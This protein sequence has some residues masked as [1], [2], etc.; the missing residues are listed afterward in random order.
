MA[1][2]CPH[3][4]AQA[5]DEAR[6]CMKCGRERT[7][8]REPD[9]QVPSAPPAAPFGQPGQPGQPPVPPLSPPAAPPPPAFAPGGPSPVGAFFGRAFRGDWAGS[10]QAALW[11]VGLLV[12]AAVALAI[13][14]YG[15]GSDVV[16]GFGDRM[17]ISLALLLQS[18][19]GGFEVSASSG[20]S[21]FGG[22]GSPFG[23]GGGDMGA[24]LSGGAALSL[25]PLTVTALWILALWIGVRVLRSRLRARAA[26]PDGHPTP[27]PGTP[28]LEA[29]LR[30]ALLVTVGVLVLGLFAQPSI[31]GVRISSSPV[32]AALGALLISLTVAAGMLH[33]DD[34]AQWLAAR[35]GASAL[36]RAT[37]TALR[38]L[39]VVLVI[40]SVTAFIGIAQIDDLG[41]VSDV[42]D[43]GQ[44]DLSP[45]VV[46][47]LVLPNLGAMALGLGWGAPISFEA[48]GS[49][50]YG[51]GFQHQAFGLS[52][53]GDATNSWA[54]VGALALGTVCALTVGVMAAR[55]SADRREQLLSAGIFLCL[56]LLLGALGGLGVQATGAASDLGG[57]GTGSAGVGL[58]MAEALLF[59]L[60]WVFAA[61]FLAPYLMQMAGART[62]IVPEP[63]VPPGA[64]GSAL[65]VPGPVTAMPEAP[66]APPA[67]SEPPAPIDPPS[68]AVAAALPTATAAPTPTPTP[69]PGPTP[70]PAAPAPIYAAHTFQLGVRPDAA[71]AKSPRR[72]GI[73]VATIAGAFVIGGGVAAGVLLL[74]DN[75]GKDDKAG[76][77]DR[78]A[79][80][81]ERPAASQQPTPAPSPTPSATPDQATE[82][83]PDV[84][85]DATVPS[86]Y[87]KVADP[88][89]F[90]FVIPDVWSRE[91][92]ENGSQIT[93]AGSTGAEHYL[94]GVIPNAGY[95]SYDNI[96]NMEKH[97]KEDKKKQDYQRIDLRRNTFQG[98]QGAIWEYTYRDEGGRTMHGIDQSY[99]AEDGTEY[100]IFLVGQQD[101]WADLKKTYRTG[102]ESW[103]LT[104]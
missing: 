84:T 75:G 12:I 62:G 61:A 17:R 79:V 101:V 77:D 8:E 86:G 24:E 27:V 25:V 69:P 95:T 94:I 40:C 91:G 90:S 22:G 42:S 72:A 9:V 93:Y 52:E 30:V 16:V 31:Q 56:F 83:A 49:S 104:N 43:L 39:A 64:F 68:P 51:G 10:A 98:R 92:V 48:G 57:S 65:G 66:A 20:S 34:L 74:Q 71:P 88:M 82:P 100:T 73:W 23:S 13:P 11:P 103:R 53:L 81:T 26:V 60:L 21:P 59:G 37:G 85:P 67:P 35:P 6:F 15:Q 47:L 58:G 97:A 28:G 18:L 5:P 102:L 1:S 99:V 19:G 54:V 76:R 2:F 36:V 96:L 70:G 63:Q 45:L 78:P 89:G 7:P 87:R 44:A 3:C 4:G 41:D 55:R 46:A 32:L 33:R 50:T 14:S 29:A 80:S 38:A